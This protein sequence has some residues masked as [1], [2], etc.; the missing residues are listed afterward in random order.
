MKRDRALHAGCQES[1]V[2]P[3]TLWLGLKERC[4]PSL[5]KIGKITACDPPPIETLE[6]HVKKIR[7]NSLRNDGHVHCAAILPHSQNAHESVSKT[8]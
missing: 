6:I 4:Y 3:R 7:P 5:V 1:E 2:C 8:T